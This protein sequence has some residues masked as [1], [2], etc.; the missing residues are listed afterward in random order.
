MKKFT[1]IFIVLFATAF[2]VS[3]SDDDSEEI[4]TPLGAYENG[5]FVLNEGTISGGTISFIGNNAIEQDV[6]GAVNP[7]IPGL[8]PYL[9]SV[10]FDDTRAFIISGY[11]QKITVV[12]RYTF[13]YLSTI[14]T[15]LYNPRYGTIIN[16]KAY[17][18]NAAD[19][20]IGADD[21]L[22]VIDLS[23]YT[24]TS[25]M[26]GNWSERIIA[27][28]G[29]LY[30]LNGYYYGSGTSVTVFNPAN[31]TLEAP[32]KLGFNPN[33]IE[34]EDGILYVLGPNKLSKINVADNTLIGAGITLPSNQNDAKN[35]DI[36]NDMIYYTNGTKVYQMAINATTAPETELFS[37]SS[38][39]QSGVMY[40]FAVKDNKIYIAD[41][42]DFASDSEIYIYSLT[43]ALQQTIPVGIGPNG[44]YFNY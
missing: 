42:G 1:R 25:V 24:T 29:K 11:G 15:N 3:C 31:N 14:S 28:D 9:Q 36:E 18:T 41:G 23:D 2:F 16:G 6:F 26:I 17:V 12:N 27:E 37:Y 4:V 13:Q 40:G 38:T 8:G 10:F 32:I 39:S 7:V 30:I 35:L 43:G 33:S 22:T 20:D 19:F 34:E 44:F 21:F 5:F